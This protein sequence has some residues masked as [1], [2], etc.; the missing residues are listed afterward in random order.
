MNITLVTGKDGTIRLTVGV[1]AVEL[2]RDKV[3]T[4]I[5]MLIDA[6]EASKLATQVYLYTECLS[7]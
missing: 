2:T 4:L 3:N 6:A 7:D 1:N 5:S